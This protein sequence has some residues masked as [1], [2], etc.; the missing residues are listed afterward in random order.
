MWPWCLTLSRQAIDCYEI[1]AVQ[2]FRHNDKV[3]ILCFSTVQTVRTVQNTRISPQL[4]GNGCQRMISIATCVLLHLNCFEINLL[5]TENWKIKDFSMPDKKV[6]IINCSFSFY[7]Q[8]MRAQTLHPW[9]LILKDDIYRSAEYRIRK[10]A[11]KTFS[12]TGTNQNGS[13]R[14]SRLRL[15]LAPVIFTSPDR[16]RRRIFWEHLFVSSV[17]ASQVNQTVQW[18]FVPEPCCDCSQALY[19]A[20]AWYS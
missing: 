20:K 19:S 8:P 6:S 18:D 11:Q 2:L 4:K 16:L 15:N 12:L 5:P 13:T 9:F 3:Q 17:E 1:S 7:S 10:T 14:I